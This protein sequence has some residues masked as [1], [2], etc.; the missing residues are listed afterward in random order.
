MTEADKIVAAIFAANMCR[1][2]PWS[3]IFKPMMTSSIR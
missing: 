1:E 2:K 3:R